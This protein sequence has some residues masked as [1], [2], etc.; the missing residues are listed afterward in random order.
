MDNTLPLSLTELRKE[1]DLLMEY[2]APADERTTLAEVA[3]RYAADIVA[4]QVLRTF[5][6]YLPEA[7]DDGIVELRRVANR[8]GV[9]LLAA[10]T[11]L[12]EYLYLADREKAEFLGPLREG[13]WD[14]EILE[15]FGW[16]DREEFLKLA[17]NPSWPIHLPVNEA[18]DLCP[19]C[20]TTDG[21]PHISG[22]PVEVCPWCGGQLI[23]C[24]CRFTETGRQAFTTEAHLDEFL[25][26]LAKKGRISFNAQEQ[27]PSFKADLD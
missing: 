7:Q 9:F 18:A 8:Q 24:Q 6:S 12:D 26:L 25:E 2:G 23:H 27:R 3:D 20:G 5:Y 22:C 14:Q 13:I 4:L 15:F 17:A 21:E 1:L 16:R 11:L 10:K 19:I